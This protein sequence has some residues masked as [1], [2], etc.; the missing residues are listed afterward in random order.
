MGAPPESDWPY[1]ISKF[2]QDV[3]AK[4]K[5]VALK[6]KV[7]SYHRVP[8]NLDSIKTAL[9]N[10]LHPISFGFLVYES[11]ETTAVAKTGIVPMPK[12]KEQ[13]MGGHAVLIVGYDDAK[14]SF[15][16]MNSWGSSW[17]DK[18]YFY[19]P[20]TYVTNSKL[21]SDFWLIKVVKE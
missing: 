3:T 21:A 2:K 7:I 6:H 5:D 10:E 12:A 17:G 4:F 9:A 13:C 20:Y 11:F 1:V 19:L 16:V 14:Q 15:I 18:G 8:Q